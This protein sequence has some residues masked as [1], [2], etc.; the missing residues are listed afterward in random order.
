MNYPNDFDTPAFPAGKSIAWSRVVAIKISIFF[1]LILCVCGLVLL[2]VRTKKNFPFL[3]SIDPLTE[4]WTVVT[5]PKKNFETTIDQSQI[6]QEKIVSDFVTNWF[7]ISPRQSENTARWA[8]CDASDCDAPE[9]YN[10]QNMEC[11]LFCVANP[12]LFAQFTQKVLPEYTARINQAAEVWTI[13]KRDIRPYYVTPDAS[14]WQVYIE[15]HSN[16]SGTF[17]VLAFIDVK[18]D[19]DTHPATLGYYIEDFNSYRLTK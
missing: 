8:E 2:F 17:N 14:A 10:P 11:A 12:D 4:E 15:M 3:I 7:T 18:R 5:Y 9:Q 16:I 1:F 6:V 13:E 19:M